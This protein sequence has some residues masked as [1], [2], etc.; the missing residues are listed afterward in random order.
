M[1]QSGRNCFGSEDVDLPLPKVVSNRFVSYVHTLH[2]HCL[3]DIPPFALF[4]YDTLCKYR[5][6]DFD[7]FVIVRHRNDGSES[8]VCEFRNLL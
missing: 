1:L 7:D 5:P 4:L 6:Y 8:V 3:Q 2:G